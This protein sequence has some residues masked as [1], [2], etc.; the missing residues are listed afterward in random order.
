MRCTVEGTLR[1]SCY[2]G[3]RQPL[4][5]EPL[6][7]DRSALQTPIART[8]GTVVIACVPRR[9]HHHRNRAVLHWCHY[10]PTGTGCQSTC[11]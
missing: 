5:V 1:L 3:I 7:C 6:Y 10:K 11:G 4:F 2:A 9:R 8:E